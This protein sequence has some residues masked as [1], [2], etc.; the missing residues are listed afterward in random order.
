MN[1]DY[2]ERKPFDLL[3]ALAKFGSENR[4]SI[5][6]PQ[7]VPK[8]ADFVGDALY[9]ALSDPALLYGQRTEAMFEAMLITLGGFS[10]LKAEDKGRVHPSERYIAPDFR[11]VLLDGTQW[12]IEVKNAY[13]EE[14]FRQ[15]R[16]FMTKGYREKLENYAAATAGQLKLAVYWARWGIW[17][18]VSPERL[19]DVDGNVT[20]D[21]KTGVFEN[22]LGFLGDRTIG[23][24]SPLRL[25][26]ET[27]PAT[28]S[29]I[30][31]DGTVKFTISE[32]RVFCAEDELLDPIKKK[33][34]WRFMLYG[35]WKVTGPETILEGGLLKAIDFLWEPEEDMNKGFEIIGDLSHMFCRYYSMQTMQDKE[36][37][38]LHAPPKPGWF[39]P[40][41]ASDYD[42]IE[43]PL[44]RFTFKPR[45]LSNS[46]LQEQGGGS[47]EVL[48][49]QPV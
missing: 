17:T 12:L 11:V 30:A 45:H 40:L 2:V 38:Q 32:V 22:E 16:C 36:V 29:P 21:M 3:A 37:V 6:D 26:L 39:A 33:L 10:L 7:A 1:S 48:P 4:I 42:N 19:A 14:P 18:L 9:S 41:L 15:E 46:L 47:A 31:T 27:D 25:R 44:W 5:N 43:L 35:D 8:F 49:P 24:R 28:T 34:A 20:L 23:T 13:I